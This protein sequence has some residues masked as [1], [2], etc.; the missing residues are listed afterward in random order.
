MDVE[1][2]GFF[3]DILVKVVPCLLNICKCYFQFNNFAFT[4]Q[5]D[6]KY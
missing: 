4:H 3:L 6:W 5:L 1:N 2:Q